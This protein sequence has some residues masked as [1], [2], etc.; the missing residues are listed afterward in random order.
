MSAI[1]ILRGRE[2]EDWVGRCRWPEPDIEARAAVEPILAAVRTRGDEAVREYTRRLDGVSLVSLEARR[3]DRR[4]ALRGLSAERRRALE[5]ARANL[6][7]FHRAQLRTESSV[8]V[9]A[10]VTVWREFRPLERVGIYVPG[11]RADYPSSVLMA[12]VPARLAG[13][14]EI[15]VCAP[16]GADGRPPVSV[17][18]VAELL[19]IE[20][21]YAIGGAQAIG[22][23]AFGTESVPRV[24][25]IVGPGNRY[26]TAAKLLVYGL[27]DI[28]MPAG[29]SEIVVLADAG[30]KP[31][32]VAADLISQA[33]HAPDAL[34]ACVTC[35]AEW[36]AR[37][38]E[39]VERQVAD[40]PRGE[41]ARESL[42]RSAICVA[43]GLDAALAWVNALAPEHLTIVTRDAEAVLNRVVHAG[44]VF[45]GP[46]TPVAAGDY[47]TGS[48]HVL[49]TARH[50][51]A[52][53]ALGVDDFGKWIQV[54][55]LTA[56]GLR[57]LAET[58][59]TLA[60]W[61]GLEAHARAVEIRV[62]DAPR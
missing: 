31:E 18:A 12:G 56:G 57:E 40:L 26:V 59:T 54:Q 35:D 7:R 11:G 24:D 10:G 30:A 55:Q 15:V 44:S 2:A 5:T 32:W 39:T 16:P 47:A 49:P 25:K 62:E 37:L 53:D 50:A 61:E 48:N 27:V 45:V 8:E 22:A 34:A 41:I 14:P 17:L 19:G 51:R 36:A 3:E 20:R 42:A 52:F 29:P 58:V 13:C 1:P 4:D 43:P 9:R 28:D 60:R 46:Y 23:L 33:E 21:V 38:A 6:E